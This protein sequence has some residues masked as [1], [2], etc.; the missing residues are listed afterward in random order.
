[1]GIAWS[2]PVRRALAMVAIL[3]AGGACSVSGQS[4][5]YAPV[6]HRTLDDPF[7]QAAWRGAQAN[8]A[9]KQSHRFVEGWLAQADEE[10]GLIPRNVRESDYFWNGKDAAADNWSFMVLAAAL[11][12]RALYRGRMHEMLRAEARLTSRRGAL[13]DPYSFRTDAFLHDAPDR[14]R[15]LFE[16]SEYVKDGLMP[17]T[18]WLGPTPFSDR[19]IDIV[20]AILEHSHFDTPFGR[21]PDNDVE[22]NGEMMQVLSRL[23]FMTGEERYLDRALQIADYY[24]LGDHHPTRDL[25]TLRLRDHGS[26]LISGLTEV[27][28]AAHFARRTEQV[29][30]YRAPLHTMLDRILDVGVNAHGMMYDEINPR[31][32]A[33]HSEHLADTWGYNYNSYYTV[34]LLDGVERYREAVRTA[35]ASLNEHYRAHNWEHG[36]ADGI[37]DAVE[38]ALNLHARE[39]DV[40]GVAAWMDAN[41]QRLLAKQQPSGLVEGWHGDGNVARTAIMW[42]LWKQQGV[43][44]RPWREDVTL[45]AVRRG[46]TLYVHVTADAAWSGSIRFDP[47]RHETVMNLPMDYPRINQFP[48]WFP[49]A[50]R[51]AYRVAP[52][53]E[54]EER[55]THPGT[56]LIEGLAMDVA[57]GEEKRFVVHP[58][59][60]RDR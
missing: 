36:S 38:S 49:V 24:L 43:T 44:L 57:A 25:D 30:A 48:A 31:T 10:T 39:G 42:A 26:E 37:A 19:M 18:E 7:E 16:S 60:A 59:A 50:P 29:E 4:A 17:I 47:P 21:L 9:L 34:Y 58:V 51:A 8:Q 13:V 3:L 35:L 28:A 56:A 11:T 6:P 40:T 54:G 12:D 14:D 15:M 2:R 23:R 33:V 55:G 46:D 52:A 20:D 27:Y 41:M 5:P 1:M 45:G 53:G 32:G 22:V